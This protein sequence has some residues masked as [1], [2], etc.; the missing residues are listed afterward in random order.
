[1]SQK[2]NKRKKDTENTIWSNAYSFRT[3]GL[4]ENACEFITLSESSTY[5]NTLSKA[6]KEVI[7][8]RLEKADAKNQDC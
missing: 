7:L 3:K 1:M 6:I 2:T 4:T 5:K 8:S